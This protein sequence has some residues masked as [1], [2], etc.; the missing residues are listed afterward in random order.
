MSLVP[1]LVLAF[2]LAAACLASRGRASLEAPLAVG[3][4]LL[5]TVAAL[6]IA[7]G[8]HL[9]LG[10]GEILLATAYGRLF[11]VL[12]SAAGLVLCLVGLATSWNANLPAALLVGLGGIGLGLSATDPLVALVVLIGTAIAAS[13]VGVDRSSTTTDILAIVRHVRLTALAGALAL[14]AL[15]WAAPALP[16]VGG[17][18]DAFGLAD[19]AIVITVAVRFGA[20]APFAHR[21]GPVEQLAP[22]PFA[23]SHAR[24]V[25]R[26]D[27]RLGARFGQ[28][29]ALPRAHDADS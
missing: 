5:V 20:G 10:S 29:G 26:S 1:F 13:L 15:A 6:A 21:V 25:V 28:T 18:A 27:E 12:G 9:R 22:S 2:G 11:V 3:S 8:D 24:R 14:V 23:A 17:N 7:P 16:R 19:L 4:L